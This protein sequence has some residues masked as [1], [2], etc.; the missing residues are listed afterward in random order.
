M[1]KESEESRMPTVRIPTPL[2]KLTAGKDE[3]TANGATVRELIDDLERQHPGLRERL[4]DDAGAIRRFV[5]I[6]KGDEDIRT[7]QGLDTTLL[8]RDELS[9]VPAIAGGTGGVPGMN[10]AGTAG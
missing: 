10:A 5:H 7:L 1:E 9:I 6:F 3:V 4:C 2:R 8:E